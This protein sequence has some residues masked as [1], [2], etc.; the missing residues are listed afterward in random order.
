MNELLGSLFII[1]VV[2]ILFLIFRAFVLW[3]WKMDKI[4]KHLETIVTL[5]RESKK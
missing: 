4:E 2:V 1:F 3:Y 5:L